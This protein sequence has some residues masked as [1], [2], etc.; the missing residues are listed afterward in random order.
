[1]NGRLVEERRVDEYL[2]D[3]KKKSPPIISPWM[4]IQDEGRQS[5]EEG[6]TCGR[7]ELRMPQ[8]AQFTL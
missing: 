3:L 6:L 1:M 8:S 2:T 4:R 7:Y 5:L